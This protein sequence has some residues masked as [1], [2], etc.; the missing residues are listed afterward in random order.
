[1]AEAVPSTAVHSQ[2]YLE[3]PLITGQPQVTERLGVQE[4]LADWVIINRLEG[5]E[6]IKIANPLL[7]SVWVLGIESRVSVSSLLT[8]PSL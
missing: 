8:E 7:H 6:D 2:S 1:M 3:Q 4:P 5:T